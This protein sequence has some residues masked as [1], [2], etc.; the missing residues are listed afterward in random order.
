MQVKVK[1][2]KY[3]LAVSGG[4]DSM[5]LLTL[6]SKLPKL[7]LAVAHFNHGI[8]SDAD[9]D[10]AFVGRAA[11]RLGVEFVAGYGRLG[12]A[13]SED[14]A[15][16]ARYKF[17]NEVKS[18]RRADG[19]ITA[20]HQDDLIETALLNL[21]RGS[22]YK[23]LVAIKA[24]PKITRPLLNTPKAEI[25]KYAKDNQIQWREDETNEDVKYLRNY[26]RRRILPKLSPAQR[27][28]LISNFDKVAKINGYLNNEIATL[29]Q[30]I[31]PAEV[32]NRSLFNTLPYGVSNELMAFWLRAYGAT[33]FDSRGI[34]RLSLALKTAK[35]GAVQPVKAG[36][37]LNISQ[38]SAHFSHSLQ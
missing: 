37:N 1:P 30:K 6:L 2:G 15:R 29:S 22:G 20:H 28:E 34:D 8:R 38:K 23:G 14:Q 17:L 35:H 5:V 13:A 25:L 19:I 21:L 16:T 26:L 31:K 3:I 10:E 9:A 12:P 11:D 32:I 4:V 27:V 36:L 24:N 18:K 7:K 33:N